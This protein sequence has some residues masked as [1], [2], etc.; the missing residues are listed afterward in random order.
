[1]LGDMVD[2]APAGG[3]AAAGDDAA[4]VAKGDGA[5][6]VPVEHALLGADRD[7]ATV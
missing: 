3:H 7:D 4:A 5:T 2:L 1:M 6:L